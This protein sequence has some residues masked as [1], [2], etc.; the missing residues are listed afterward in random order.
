MLLLDDI[1]LLHEEVVTEYLH[2]KERFVFA[3]YMAVAAGFVLLN[4]KEILASEYA[5]LLLAFALF[6]ASIFFDVLPLDDLD[7]PYFWE[8]LEL[9][10]EDG[11]KFA[12]IATWLMYLARY[13]V[14]RIE[15]TP[16]AHQ[17]MES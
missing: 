13:A 6:A 2:L 7:L 12:G 4:W 16:P 9:F 11:L 3:G 1:F 5:L 8:Q 15:G 10:F 14:R 17:A